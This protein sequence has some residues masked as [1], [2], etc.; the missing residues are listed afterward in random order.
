M[1]LV[2]ARVK[3]NYC[4]WEHSKWSNWRSRVKGYYEPKLLV[5]QGGSQKEPV[6]C[7]GSPRCSNWRSKVKSQK[8]CIP[9][10][11]VILDGLFLL[12]SLAGRKPTPPTLRY[13]RSAVLVTRLG[14]HLR[15][16]KQ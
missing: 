7:A 5:P 13:L 4:G 11:S 14:E 3:E 9:G 12:Q 6:R 10:F 1:F 2:S 16:L 15:S 8:N